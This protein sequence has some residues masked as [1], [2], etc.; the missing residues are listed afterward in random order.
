[1]TR[2]F[3]KNKEGPAP[4]IVKLKQAVVRIGNNGTREGLKLAERVFKAIR[5]LRSA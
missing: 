5:E 3:P 4:V 2:L 1:V